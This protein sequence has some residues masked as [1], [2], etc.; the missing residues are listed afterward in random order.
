MK[1][2]EK[3]RFFW[4]KYSL[5][6]FALYVLY[7][8]SLYYT[9]R[10]KFFRWMIY[11]ILGVVVIVTTSI[12]LKRFIGKIKEREEIRKINKLKSSGQEEY[13]KRFI[14]NYGLEG[15][16]SKAH[17][18]KFR[19]HVFDFDRIN[20]L[21]KILKEKEAVIK[22]E[23]V[24]DLLRFYIQEK[25]ESVTRESIQYQPREF[26]RL[27]GE[28]FEGLLQRLFDAMGYKTQKIGHTGD[29]GGDLI[30]N[31]GDERILIQAKCYRDWSV[32]NA[33]VQQVVGALKYYNCNQAKV[34]TTSHF[35]TE[36]INLAKANNV[37]LVSKERLQDLLLNSLKESW[38]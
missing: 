9:D 4:L 7:L 32:G 20:D 28:D 6:V 17:M 31:R 26:S 1:M 23:D 2:S 34:I 29:Q 35:T 22:D 21:K 25:E 19:N 27:S 36:A 11:N 18:W 38:R 30:A 15:A 33:A 16:R 24:Y 12:L 3:E 10:Q 14:S 13:L 5:G 8:V 37:D